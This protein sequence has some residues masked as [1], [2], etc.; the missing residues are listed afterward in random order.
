MSA[1]PAKGGGA[2]ASAGWSEGELVGLKVRCVSESLTEVYQRVGT[3]L[4]QKDDQIEV[5]VEGVWSK[6]IVFVHQV[7]LRPPLAEATRWKTGNLAIRELQELCARFPEL[8]DLQKEG[9]ESRLTG[10]HLL[11]GSWLLDRD[12]QWIAAGAYQLVA[13]HVVAC[14][15]DGESDK[16]VSEEDRETA[17]KIILGKFERCGLL[18]F[19]IWAKGSGG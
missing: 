14:F 7:E 9:P 6:I 18:G 10:E 12:L 1:E 11:V 8:D 2:T 19:P 4:G 3:V 13:P 17:R 16:E 5:Q 15:A